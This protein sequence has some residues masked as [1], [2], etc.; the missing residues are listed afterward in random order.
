MISQVG[1]ESLISFSTSDLFFKATDEVE[2]KTIPSNNESDVPA[3]AVL[4]G[5][6][7]D[8]AVAV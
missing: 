6:G 8:T 4:P 1:T 5:E 7:K 3:A 2:P